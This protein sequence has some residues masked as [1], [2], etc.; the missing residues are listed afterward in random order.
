MQGF[1]ERFQ[2]TDEKDVFDWLN[3]NTFY[4]AFS[5]GWALYAENP[6]LSTDTDLYEGELMQEYGML[7]LQIW[8]ALRMVIDTGL[9]ERGKIFCTT[10]KMSHFFIFQI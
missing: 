6:L 7:R 4:V 5:E 9:H 8:R 3:V 10:M 1:Y 2:Q